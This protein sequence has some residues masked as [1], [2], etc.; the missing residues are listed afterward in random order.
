MT[1]LDVVMVNYRTPDDRAAFIDSL[2]EHLPTVDFTF[3]VV[4]VGVDLIS[5][6]DHDGQA[7]NVETIAMNTWRI[8]LSEN[9]G[10]ARACNFGAAMGTSEIIGLFN[11]DVVLTADAIDDCCAA[12]AEHDEWG[13]L[14]P[15]QV[16]ARGRLRH[17]GIFGSHEQPRHRGWDEPNRGQY[18]DVAPAVSVSGSA[19]FIKRKVWQ[20]LTDCTLYQEIAPDAGGAFLPTAHYYEET[21]ASYHAHAHGHQV[22]YFGEATVIHKWHQASPIGG[23]AD[24]QMKESRAYFRAACDHHGIAHD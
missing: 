21:W 3:T 8:A 1:G 7:A 24:R 4:D 10:Y 23:W 9:V 15:R 14:G 13:I 19:Y 12:L 22:I 2:I 16:D 11:A 18:Q 5:S 20:E 6:M 17:A